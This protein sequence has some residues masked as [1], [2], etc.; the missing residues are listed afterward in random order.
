MLI[1]QKYKDRLGVQRVNH[2]KL[3]CKVPSGTP[4]RSYLQITA[5]ILNTHKSMCTKRTNQRATPCM[6]SYRL[7]SSWVH[8]IR[9]C[10]WSHPIQNQIWSTSVQHRHFFTCYS[11]NP[12]SSLSC[13]CHTDA[14]LCSGP[15]GRTYGTCKVNAPCNLA[16]NTAVALEVAPMVVFSYRPWPYRPM[17]TYP[18]IV[19][20]R[21]CQSYERTV[22]WQP[23]LWLYNLQS[24]RRIVPWQTVLSLY[25]YRIHSLIAV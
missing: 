17:T 24:Y 10:S 6:C 5:C 1:S 13:K 21:R 11:A 7:F 8:L 19:L 25:S 22:L 2:V 23:V 12:L 16:S 18:M 9:R 14:V 4:S 20:S 3:L 15:G